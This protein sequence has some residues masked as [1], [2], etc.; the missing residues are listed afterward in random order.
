MKNDICK[1]EDHEFEYDDK[2]VMDWQDN[3]YYEPVAC[4]HC[5]LKGFNVYKLVRT[6]DE[7]SNEIGTY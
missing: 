3:V 5:G 1:P 6:I 7:D 2:G 4:I